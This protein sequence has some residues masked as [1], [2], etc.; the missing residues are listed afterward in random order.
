MTFVWPKIIKKYDFS[1][2]FTNRKILF[3]TL[4]TCHEELSWLPRMT[5]FENFKKVWL[6]LKISKKY[7]FCMTFVWPIKKYDFVWLLYDCMTSYQP[8]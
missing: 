7:D 8:C 4:G 1:D 6:S 5:F 3:L 2:E